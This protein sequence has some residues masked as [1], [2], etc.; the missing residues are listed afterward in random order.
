MMSN[1]PSSRSS[2]L[3]PCFLFAFAGCVADTDKEPGTVTQA[4]QETARYIVK[5][6]NPAQG[7]AA[8][9]NIGGVLARDLPQQ[10]AAA[11]H[12]NTN[13]AAGLANNPHIDYIEVDQRRVPLAETVPYGIT[14]VQ[15]DQFSEGGNASDITVCIIDSGYQKT[16]TDLRPGVTGNTDSGSGDPFS[17][18]CGHGTHVAG[19]IAAI[20]GNSEGVVGV[21]P[22]GLVKL[23]IVKVFGNA[24]DPCAWS[25]SS[26]LVAAANE[27]AA[28]NANIISM[29]L[30]CSGGPKNGPFACSSRTERDTF[31]DLAAD[32]ILS[33]AAAGN[34][35]NTDHSYPASYDSVMSVAAIDINEVVA[36]FSQQNDQVEIA[37]PGV[38]VLST[39]PMG[40]GRDSNFTAGGATFASS[41]MDEA[42]LTTPGF[43][44]AGPLVDCGTGEATCTNAAGAVCLIQRGTIS[45][46]DKVLACEA[47]GGVA[48]VIYNNEPGM[49]NGTMGGV[50]TTIPS[51]GIS[52]TDGALLLSTHLGASATVSLTPTN[53]SAWNGTSMA[54]PHVAGVAALVWSH[55]SSWTAAQIRNALTSTAKDLG[56]GGRDDAYGYGLVQAKAALDFL[57]TPSCVP[58]E[59]S[60]TSCS[61]GVDNDCDGDTDA[62]DSDCTLSCTPTE[63]SETSC[64]DGVDNDCDG[65]TDAD[66]SDCAPTCTPSEA[67]ETSCTD[68][69]DNDCDGDIDGD[70]SDCQA[71]SCTLGQPGDSCTSASDCCSNRCKGKSGSKTCK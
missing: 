31:A 54:T 58:T 61:D 28:N 68:G 13:A 62:D 5:F 46:A 14:M 38:S 30:G 26:D 50:A 52:D 67:S 39:V 41:G 59:G 24:E 56:A 40:T 11:Y 70:D 47:G 36:T 57:N 63:S 37:A 7:K 69:Q 6:K 64:S 65:D 18:S 45:F 27:C 34:D 48:A 43:P 66:D 29:S 35:G 2:L 9:A 42:P 8:V 16:H 53:Y 15:A 49:L 12:L 4:S 71:G 25:Y 33:I 3:V 44:A 20:G 21:V 55:N 51:V 1:H 19:T 60:E 32:D 17:D 22:N 10:S 23:H